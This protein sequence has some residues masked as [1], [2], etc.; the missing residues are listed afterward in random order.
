MVKLARRNNREKSLE[1]K[2]AEIEAQINKPLPDRDKPIDMTKAISTGSTLLDLTISGRRRR[3]GGIPGGIIV[4]IFGKPSSGKTALL[5]EIIAST[6]ARDGSVKYL[7]PEG[8]LD[9][10]YSRIYGVSLEKK[11]YYRPKSVRELFDTH[12]KGWKPKNPDVINAIAADSLAALCSDLDLDGGDKRGQQRAKLFSEGCRTTAIDIADNNWLIA[13]S[14]QVRVGEHGETVPGGNAIPFYASLR[15]RVD[16]VNKIEREITLKNKD[17][18]NKG[19]KR[20]DVTIKKVIGIESSCF[21]RKS[22]I[23]RP[24]REC[25]IYILFDY[26]IDTVRGDLQYIKDMTGNTVYDCCDGKTYM[27]LDKAINYVEENNLQEKL[28][29]NVIELWNIIENKFQITRQPKVRI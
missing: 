23:D 15:I 3:E 16:M 4:E 19:D 2:A 27:S 1:E 29:N 22:S 11:D 28:K 24:F 7:D 25:S 21:I 20:K 5:S 12:I 26:G 6:Q 14:N 17:E 9:L 10:E 18:E 13:C 8:R